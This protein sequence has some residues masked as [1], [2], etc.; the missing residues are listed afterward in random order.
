M[1]NGRESYYFARLR[2]RTLNVCIAE[3]TYRV[4]DLLN[5][6]SWVLQSL[7]QHM[8]LTILAYL[9]LTLTPL[10]LGRPSKA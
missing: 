2:G 5:G 4:I 9:L 6:D 1:Q 10:A 3:E 8:E 7:N